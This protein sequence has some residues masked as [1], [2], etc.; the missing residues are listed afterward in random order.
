MDLENQLPNVLSLALR[1]SVTQLT[2]ISVS[3]S[4][5]LLIAAELQD[6]SG[7]KTTQLERRALKGG[8]RGSGRSGG[9]SGGRTPGSVVS[10]ATGGSAHS[11]SRAAATTSSHSSLAVA[12][13]ASLFVA[14]VIASV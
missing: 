4:F 10:G 11:H 14:A 2:T 5:H 1:Q 9:S 6:D 7:K 3:Y 12:V 8:G 13:S